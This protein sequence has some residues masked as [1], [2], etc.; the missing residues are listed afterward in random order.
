MKGIYGLGYSMPEKDNKRE[1]KIATLVKVRKDLYKE[2]LNTLNNG[3]NTLNNG[4]NTLNNGSNTLNNGSNTL[5]NGSNTLNN[6]SN[7]LNNGSNTL[8]N[9]S[10]TLNNG[11]NTLNNG[12]NTLNDG[13]NTLNNGSNALNAEDVRRWIEIQKKK[14]ESK[15]DC[16]PPPSFILSVAGGASN[17]L[18][19]RR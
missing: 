9:G 10:N 3:S 1:V 8:N 18:L 17:F 4:S 14:E 19:R 6:G 7:T 12:S 11:S 13:S 15:I 5:N 16:V 2:D